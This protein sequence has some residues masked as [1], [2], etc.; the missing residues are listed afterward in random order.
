[1]C[2]W[3][4]GGGK[5]AVRRC[6]AALA[7]AAIALPLAVTPSSSARSVAPPI[8]R[9]ELHLAP[10][11]RSRPQLLLMTLGGP[12]YCMQLLNLAR[13]V[14]ASL[15]CTDYGR[16]R[17]E[18]PGGR[19]GRLEDWGDPLYLR[20]VAQL[21]GRLRN[22]GI[23]ISKLVLVG[24]SYSGYADAELVATHP[25]LHAAA[26]VVVDSYL[27]LPARY[28]ALAPRGETRREIETVLGGTLAQER[29]AYAE[30]SPSHHLDGLAV[31]I[32]KGM[33]LVVVW[34]TSAAEEKEF[35]GA[36]CSR[37]ANAE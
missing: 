23:N 18:G 34:S 32:E 27:D 16:N 14:H 21:P 9:V 3:N 12:I 5:R 25:E 37:D 8:M 28:E 31:A 33:R 7:V 29:R 30:R 6:S 4:H 24:V 10:D 22:E 20:A 1:M 13:N 2:G 36:T 26:L 35:R 15:A 11:A 19:A 17:Y